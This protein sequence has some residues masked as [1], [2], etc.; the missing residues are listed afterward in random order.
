MRITVVGTGYV[1]LVSGVCLS[2]KGHNVICVD[3]NSDKVQKINNG[4]SPIYEDGL[5]ELLKRNIGERLTASTDLR[6]AI[7]NSD[8]SLIAVGTPFNGSVI[9]LSYIR[10]VSKEIGKCLSS[11]DEYHVVIVKSTVVPGTTDDIVKPLLEKYSQKLAGKDF[12]IGMNPEFLREGLAVDDF[13]NPDRIVLGGSDDLT[14][15]VMDEL[16]EPFRDVDTIFT[17]NKTAEMIKY[18][19]NSLLATLISF[20]NEVGNLCSTLGGI[21]AKEVMTGIHLDKRFSP[22]LE[23]G[24]RI[25]P[26]ITSYIEVGCGFGGSCLPKDVDALI[27]HGDS[28]NQPM[29]LLKSVMLINKSQPLE[30]INLL[31]KHYPDINGLHITILG[32]AFKPGTDDMRESPSISIINRIVELGGIVNAYDPIAESNARE[33]FADEDISY[34]DSLEDSIK[35]SEVVLLLTSW[36]EFQNLPQLIKSLNIDPLVID[37]R[38]M[39]S[40][41]DISRYEGIGN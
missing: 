3:N 41:H 32:L 30:I 38:R 35:H 17:N 7:N 4:V 36:P 19:S 34:F 33:I 15:S 11:K 6:S 37:G 20:S 13:M 5:N 40:K 23:S 12:G 22:I 1:G 31:I 18:A 28:V 29:P 16:Y 26:G 2:E 10:Q 25:T 27:S 39:L 8:I 9:D 21:D 14:H 24:Q